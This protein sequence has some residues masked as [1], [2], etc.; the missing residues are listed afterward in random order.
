[1]FEAMPVELESQ[2]RNIQTCVGLRKPELRVFYPRSCFKAFFES[3]QRQRPYALGSRTFCFQSLAQRTRV[4]GLFLH[5]ASNMVNVKLRRTHSTGLFVSQG[6]LS[7]AV[8]IW[9]NVGIVVSS[10]SWRD[11]ATHCRL[12]LPGIRFCRRSGSVDMNWACGSN[13]QPILS[14]FPLTQQ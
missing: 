9:L 12:S 11:D 7:E 14:S 10:G 2:H 8:L 6:S 1:M 3:I 4:T 5:G 13:I